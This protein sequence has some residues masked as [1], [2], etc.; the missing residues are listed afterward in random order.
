L[1]AR[2]LFLTFTTSFLGR[3]DFGLKDRLKTEMSGIALWA[4][5]GLKRL[6]E[7]GEFTLPGDASQMH[8]D[9]RNLTCPIADFADTWVFVNKDAVLTLTALYEAWKMYTEERSMHRRSM[10]WLFQ[11]LKVRFPHIGRTNTVIDGHTV[12]QV[13]GLDLHDFTA[14]AARHR[15][16]G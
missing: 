14:N 7:N 8:T 11:Q 4:L 9:F 13:T 1:D 2:L 16:T 10:E 6:H 5:A 15:R 3:E 12:K